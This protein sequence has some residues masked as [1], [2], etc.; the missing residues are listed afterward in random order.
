MLSIVCENYDYI[1]IDSAPI[2][3]VTDAVMLSSM[4]DGVILVANRRTARQ[5]VKTALSLLEY[6]RAK[7]FGIV[8]NQVERG[9]FG[10]YGYK[11]RYYLHE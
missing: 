10:Y 1:I 5:Q 4:V 11:S 8:L 7:V 6:A 2:T 3:V 9:Q